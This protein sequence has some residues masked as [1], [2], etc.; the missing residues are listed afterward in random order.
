MGGWL[1]VLVDGLLAVLAGIGAAFAVIV[2]VY[3]LYRAARFVGW[4]TR[5]MLGDRRADGVP[6]YEEEDYP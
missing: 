5:L 6:Y 4:L 1:W 2:S 3:A